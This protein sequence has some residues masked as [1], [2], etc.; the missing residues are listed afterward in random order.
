MNYRHTSNTDCLVNSSVEHNR[1]G[2]RAKL[3]TKNIMKYHSKNRNKKEDTGEF[4]K[5]NV[6]I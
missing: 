3:S 6:H 5:R 4:V 2:K 1:K